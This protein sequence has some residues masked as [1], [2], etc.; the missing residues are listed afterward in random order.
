MNL[1]FAETTT[2]MDKAQIGEGYP[3]ENFGAI[4]IDWAA[5]TVSLEVRS[6]TG[7]TVR[8]AT[9]SFR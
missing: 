7:E 8:Q 4:G 5:G 6:N 1:S 3:P 2:E 9:T